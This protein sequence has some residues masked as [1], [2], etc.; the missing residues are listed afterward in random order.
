[1]KEARRAST[2]QTVFHCIIKAREKKKQKPHSYNQ[3]RSMREYFL[4]EAQ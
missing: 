3:Q 1:M 2:L 4:I